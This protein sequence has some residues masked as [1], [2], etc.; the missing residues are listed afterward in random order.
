MANLVKHMVGFTIPQLEWLKAEARR[1]GIS[2]PDL[3]RRIVDQAR[4]GEKST[5]E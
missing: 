1:L 3:V 5:T 4:T 2:M